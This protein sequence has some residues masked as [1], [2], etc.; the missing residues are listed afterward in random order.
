MKTTIPAALAALLV[1]GC[2]GNLWGLPVPPAPRRTPDHFRGATQM[3]AAGASTQPPADVPT[4]A[5]L[6]V[7][8]AAWWWSRRLRRHVTNRGLG[9]PGRRQP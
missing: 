7:V 8:I 6:P 4:P 3:V 5:G 2:S 1:T 9:G